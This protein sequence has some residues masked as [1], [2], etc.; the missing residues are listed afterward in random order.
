MPNV[1]VVHDRHK[2][3]LQ[4]MND[5]KYGSKE[6]EREAQ[7]PNVHSRWCIRH[8]QANLHSQFNNK[9]LTKLFKWLCEQ[10]QE[11]KF[12]EI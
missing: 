10:N 7:W 6:R 5:I 8:M 11:R 1:C 3:I 12:N 2:D 9:A 4:V